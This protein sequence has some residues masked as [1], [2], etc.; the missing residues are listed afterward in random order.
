V[1][2]QAAP[3]VQP[4]AVHPYPTG[5]GQAF[6]P[7]APAKKGGAGPIIAVVGTVVGVA[8]IVGV[9]FALKSKKDTG[10]GSD[11]IALPTDAP[12]ATVA[13]DPAPTGTGTGAAAATTTKPVTTGKTAP[14]NPSAKPSATAST[15]ADA[16]CDMAISLAN[17]S[18]T[19][20]AV[21]HF[22]SCPSSS[23]RRSAALAAID[24]SAQ[25]EVDRRG[26]VAR[27]AAR[28]AASVGASS[29]MSALRAKNCK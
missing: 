18:N 24:A 26:C 20:L 7:P 1:V 22:R 6:A 21:S 15:G 11:P 23:P 5:G 10:P 13:S 9:V 25:R 14:P 28:A 16:E 27:G 8:V 3:A 19:E 2:D 29:A 12:T 4:S 17:G